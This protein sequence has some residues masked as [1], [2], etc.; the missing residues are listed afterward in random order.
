VKLKDILKPENLI[1]NLEAEGPEQVL[2]ELVDLVA[3]EIP[4]PKE[5]LVRVLVERENQSPTAMS[6]GVAVPHGRI[7]ELGRFILAV[8]RSPRGIDF[9][10][11]DGRTKIFFLLMAPTDDTVSHLKILARIARICR[12]QALK[13]DIM[14]A[15]TAEEIY[16]RLMKEDG[17]T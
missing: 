11:E 17:E 15:G 1:S 4:L 14:S 10:G 8:G 5:E 7:P 2:S 6:G 3:D 13:N 12:N 9:G 16:Q